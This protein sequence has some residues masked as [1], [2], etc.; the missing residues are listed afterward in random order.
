[1][2]GA[3]QAAHSSAVS[4]HVVCVPSIATSTESVSVRGRAV[5]K[6]WRGM[7]PVGGK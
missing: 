3:M 6:A 2:Y 4:A 1:M 5:R 7:L